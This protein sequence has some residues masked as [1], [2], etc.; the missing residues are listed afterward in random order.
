VGESRRNGLREPDHTGF[1]RA[2]GKNVERWR[3][4]TTRNPTP[5]SRRPAWSMASSSPTRSAACRDAIQRRQCLGLRNGYGGGG[6]Q[7]VRAY[8]GGGT[9][10]T[11]ESW[12]SPGTDTHRR[13]RM[14]RYQH[15]SHCSLDRDRQGG[16]TVVSSQ[17]QRPELATVYAVPRRRNGDLKLLVITRAQQVRLMASPALRTSCRRVSAQ[18]W[19]YGEASGHAPEAR[20]LMA[21]PPWHNRT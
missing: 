18:L 4:S 15:Y 21:T 9:A 14:C 11:T 17:Q 20:P 19:Q 8:Y 5:A 1:R 13:E 7:I 2:K 12:P 3:P 6:Q 10:A 16:G